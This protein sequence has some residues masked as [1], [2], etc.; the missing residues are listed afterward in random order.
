MCAINA[1]VF[2]S[3]D[4]AYFFFVLSA[5]TQPDFF[6]SALTPPVFFLNQH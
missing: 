5:L 1:S 3:T 4:S 6:S 2:I